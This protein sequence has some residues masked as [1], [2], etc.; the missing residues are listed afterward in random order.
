ME[1]SKFVQFIFRKISEKIQ[2]L[3]EAGLGNKC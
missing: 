3:E 2:I 1:N